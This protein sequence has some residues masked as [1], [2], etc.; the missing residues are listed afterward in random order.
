MK[1]NKESSITG[2]PNMISYESSKKI[3]EQMEKNICKINIGQIQGTGFFCKI[4][5]PD[6]KNM[7]PVLITNNHIINR[8]I[9]NDENL[10][11]TIDIKEELELLELDLNDRKKYTNEEYDITIIEIK[12]KDQINNYIELDDIIMNDILF[13]INKIKEYINE[14]VHIIQYPENKLSVSY[15]VL[16]DIYENKK[17]NFNHKCST[18][19]GSSGSPILDYF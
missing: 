6:K 11:V 8:Y 3:I 2:Y 9:L 19:G 13:N 4:P 12:D 18:R 16:N 1:E 5:F 10:K 7:L 17:Y 15:G 14:T